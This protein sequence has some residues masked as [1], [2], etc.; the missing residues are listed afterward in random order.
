[1]SRTKAYAAIWAN[2]ALAALPSPH[3]ASATATL[4]DLLVCNSVLP[5]SSC[6]ST[7]PDIG[8]DIPTITAMTIARIR[9][10][11]ELGTSVIWGGDF[12]NTLA[13]PHGPGTKR[14]RA[15]IQR[16]VD[17]LGLQVPTTNLPHRLPSLSAIDHIAVP[18]SWTVTGCVAMSAKC[19]GVRLSDHDAYVIDVKP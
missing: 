4:G 18:A 2:R 11:L 14:G 5:W 17:D 16:L 12:N 15:E 10:H 9:S 8:P 13:G 1:M 3:E 19:N 7:W 6:R